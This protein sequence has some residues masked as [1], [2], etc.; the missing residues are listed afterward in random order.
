MK[1][2]IIPVIILTIILFAGTGLFFWKAGFFEKTERTEYLCRADLLFDHLECWEFIEDA[3]IN[4]SQYEQSELG[5]IHYW[6]VKQLNGDA[7]L[8]GKDDTYE[9]HKY[10][11]FKVIN[12]R[13]LN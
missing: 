4:W 5:I 9:N 2:I 13:D 6:R 8:I 10:M 7:L 12:I 3:T 11:F 1:K